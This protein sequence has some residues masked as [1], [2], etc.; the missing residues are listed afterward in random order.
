MPLS[1]MFLPQKLSAGR[2]VGGGQ[3]QIMRWN[4]HIAAAKSSKQNGTAARDRAR[5]A[6]HWES[7]NP[8][9]FADRMSAVAGFVPSGI[10]RFLDFF[11]HNLQGGGWLS[12]I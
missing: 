10:L 11:F 1:S 12:A 9:G 3:N 4:S 2:P 7:A 8:K 5:L 6:H